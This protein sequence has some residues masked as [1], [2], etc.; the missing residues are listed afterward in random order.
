[1]DTLSTL[2]IGS[3]LLPSLNMQHK[4]I[5]RFAEHVHAHPHG[6]HCA[7]AADRKHVEVQR[8]APHQGAAEAGD[9]PVHGV[10]LDDLLHVEPADGK[11]H[12]GGVI[13][14]GGEVE[15]RRDEHAP[16]V[17]DV[18]EEHRC[19]RQEQA[20]PQTEEEE[21]DERVERFQKG[22]VEGRTGKDH[23]QQQGHKAEHAVHHGKAALFQREDILGD[24]HLFQQGGGAEHAAHA[25]GG[26]LVEEVE[27]QLTAHQEHREVVDAAAPHIHQAAEHGPVDQAHQQGVQHAPQHTQHAAAVF[28]LEIT[29]NQVLQ[30]VTVFPEACEGVF[31]V[32]HDVSLW[33]SWN[34]NNFRYIAWYRLLKSRGDVVYLADLPLRPLSIPFMI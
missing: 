26:G 15:Q 5:L 1:M 20:H 9:I 21:G 23:H 8:D 22:Q 2:M 13:E 7:D 25:G 14:D 3:I 34:L 31:Q 30:Q 29:G 27:E 33:L 32:L 17:H 10:Q 28:Q 19:R 16:D 18:P 12:L 11:G 6:D 4:T 24:I